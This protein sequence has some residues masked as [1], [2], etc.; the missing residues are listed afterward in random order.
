MKNKE[1]EKRLKRLKIYGILGI[2]YSAYLVYEYLFKD[3]NTWMLIIAICLFI[4]SIIF[5]ISSFWL[6]KHQKYHTLKYEEYK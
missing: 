5:I 6:K 1:F 2:I 4:I 3:K